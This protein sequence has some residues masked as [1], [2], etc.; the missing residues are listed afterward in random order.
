MVDMEE[1][2]LLNCNGTNCSNSTVSETYIK[3]TGTILF[4][5]V[6][7]FIVL[8]M[9][10]FPLGR[11]AAALVGATLMVLFQVVT[12]SDVYVIEGD[13]N[14]LQTIFLLV[15][16]MMLSYYYDREGILKVIM[17]KIFGQNKPFYTLLWKICLMSAVLSAFITN[18]ATCLVITPLLLT[19][20]IKQGRDKSE[21]LPLCLGIATSANIGS[22]ATI[23]GNPQNAYIASKISHITLLNFLI[24]ELPAALL[25]LGINIILLYLFVFIRK[26]VNNKLNKNTQRDS[27]TTPL[28]ESTSESRQQ[29]ANS[30]SLASER[31]QFAISY[32]ASVDPMRTSQI[33]IERERMLSGSSSASQA[34]DNNGTLI[35]ISSSASQ[36]QDNNGTQTSINPSLP[37]RYR[38]HHQPVTSRSIIELNE[39]TQNSADLRNRQQNETPVTTSQKANNDSEVHVSV[40][41][42]HI[43]KC[44]QIC[45]KLFIVWLIFITVFMIVLLAIPPSVAEFNLGCIPL[46][47]SILTMLMDTILNRKYAYDV[48]LKIDWTVILMFMGLF[49]WLEGFHKTDFPSDAFNALKEHMNLNQFSGVL[50]FSVFIIVGS[51]LLSN[52]PLVILFADKTGELCT[53]CGPLGGLLLAWISTVAG[54]FTLIGSVANLIVAEK[55]RSS[56]AEYRF[57]FFNYLIFGLPSTLMVLYICLPIVYYLGYYAADKV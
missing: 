46:G 5:I 30:K 18:D 44:A 1:Y 39:S 21:L 53:S 7:P 55:A 41:N 31:H 23:F 4:V 25:G 43:T 17:L 29:L 9:K 22:A 40:K 50:L 38:C 8:D 2:V 16:M 42:G 27:E 15:G 35:R 6:W 48:M 34:Q 37:R 52:V 32:D 3:A 24:A 14:N 13:K 54:N 47:A 10:F 56:D 57:T 19:E 33:S 36:A 45:Q 51:N 49:I 28:L 26:S 11:P 12:Q 20:F